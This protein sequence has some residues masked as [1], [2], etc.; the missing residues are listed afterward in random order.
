MPQ[1]LAVQRMKPCDGSSLQEPPVGRSILDLPGTT[2]SL[3]AYSVDSGSHSI[4][5]YGTASS[6]Q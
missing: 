2:A 4:L 6:I 3:T 5:F 1:A